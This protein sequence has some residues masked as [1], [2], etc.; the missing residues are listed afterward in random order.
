[1]LCISPHPE[2]HPS[3][4]STFS[5][6]L[7]QPLTCYYYAYI[8]ICSIIIITIDSDISYPG[9]LDARREAVDEEALRL[10]VL[11]HHLQQKV[12]HFHLDTLYLQLWPVHLQISHKRPMHLQISQAK[13]GKN[14]PGCGR[15]HQLA[16]KSDTISWK[17]W[18]S[19]EGGN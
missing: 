8:L 19:Q 7:Q 18:Q 13:T 12:C 3:I 6:K 9:L 10:L 2:I 16:I 14:P 15:C 1:M 11:P 4:Q 5:T 17:V